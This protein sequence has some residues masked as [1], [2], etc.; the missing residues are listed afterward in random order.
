MSVFERWERDLDQLKTEGRHRTLIAPAGIDFSS[1][2]YLGYSKRT[3][4]AGSV[5]DWSSDLCRSGTASRLLRGHHPIWDE[6]ESALAAWHGAEAVL[7]MTSGYAANEGLLST[8]ATAG[9]TVFSDQCNHASIIDGLRLSRADKVVFTHNNLKELEA[10]L[11]RRV[12]RRNASEAWF[13][14]TESLFGM[15]GDIAPLCQMAELSERFQAHLI[16]DEAH[17]TGCFGPVGSGLVD[18]MDVRGRVLATVHTGGKALAVPGAY[19]A[20]SKLLK[21]L[22][23][24]RCRHL[25]YTTALPPL[26]GS[27]WL[28]MLPAVQIDETARRALRAATQFF[29][30]ELSERNIATSGAGCIVPILLGADAA[31]VEAARQLQEAGFDVRAIRP[32]SVAEGTARLRISIHADHEPAVLRQLADSLS[33]FA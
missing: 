33:T 15:E 20:G 22:L 17:A 1:N 27:W 29:R 31:A 3:W 10:Q 4:R 13:I 6:V 8:V 5:P 18:A 24:N 14:V 9:D 12:H 16:V 7:M 30:E 25:I 32:P 19:I 11:R 26:I 23:V 21:D 2:D 28:D